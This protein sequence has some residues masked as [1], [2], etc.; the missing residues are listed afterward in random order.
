M[1][2]GAYKGK[3]QQKLEVMGAWAAPARHKGIGGAWRLQGESRSGHGSGNQ[4]K[5]D[6]WH[7]T[8]HQG[9]AHPTS[10]HVYTICSNERVHATHATPV[11]SRACLHVLSTHPFANKVAKQPLLVSYCH[12]RGSMTA[13]AR[14]RNTYHQQT[15]SSQN[16]NI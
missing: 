7:T 12:E 6:S 16:L 10:Q 2:H 11:R 15:I 9:W 4:S 14:F 3:S 1:A 8:S 13:Q 5:I